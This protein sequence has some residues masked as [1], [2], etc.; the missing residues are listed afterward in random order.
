MILNFK[1]IK[2]M[3]IFFMLPLLM[4]SLQTSTMLPPKCT[5][6]PINT[7]DSTKIGHFSGRSPANS[8]LKFEKI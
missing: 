5:T 8:G 1:K 7:G 3:K 6:R 4:F 2:I